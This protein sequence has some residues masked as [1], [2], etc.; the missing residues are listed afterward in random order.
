MTSLNTRAD[1]QAI[2][3]AV[4]ESSFSFSGANAACPEW[5]EIHGVQRTVR[6]GPDARGSVLTRNHVTKNASHAV[7]CRGGWSF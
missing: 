4:G 5:V 2:S 3:R 1:R 7:F 6:F